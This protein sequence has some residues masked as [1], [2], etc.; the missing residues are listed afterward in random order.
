M[1]QRGR[2]DLLWGWRKHENHSTG[3]APLKAYFFKSRMNVY[4]RNLKKWKMKRMKWNFFEFHHVSAR[5]LFGTARSRIWVSFHFDKLALGYKHFRKSMTTWRKLLKWL[6]SKRVTQVLIKF[7]FFFFWTP[8]NGS[9]V[10]VLKSLSFTL[11][12]RVGFHGILNWKF[13]I[14]LACEWSEIVAFWR[15]I[16]AT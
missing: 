13:F 16:I 7:L 9:I 3:D 6:G 5:K 12:T 14:F 1:P 10:R 11:E 4:G 2:W 15:M 8:R